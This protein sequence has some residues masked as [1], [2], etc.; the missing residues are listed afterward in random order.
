M[1]KSCVD[2]PQYVVKQIEP[3]LPAFC[4]YWKEGL[5]L[6]SPTCRN[7]K[8]GRIPEEP[9]S[10]LSDLPTAAPH[11]GQAGSEDYQFATSLLPDQSSSNHG[12]DVYPGRHLVKI[13]SV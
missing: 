2:C 12:N 1:F 11:D 3:E 5:R 9:V 13:I 7:Y 10:P 4:L 8:E 6:E